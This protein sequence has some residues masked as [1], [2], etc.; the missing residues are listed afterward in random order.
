M[1]GMYVH[2]S[3]H[4]N[5][6][7]QPDI[8]VYIFRSEQFLKAMKFEFVW[9]DWDPNVTPDTYTLPKPEY[10]SEMLFC[11]AVS[12][13]TAVNS[14]ISTVCEWIWVKYNFVILSF[15]YLAKFK[16][17]INMHI[18]MTYYIL[19]HN[20]R[21]ICHFQLIMLGRHHAHYNHR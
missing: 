14:R 7:F 15:F 10:D 13:I 1:V 11:I 3:P 19:I 21:Q 20:S 2:H 18:Y 4:L 16:Q 5:I 6:S 9:C 12:L 8:S 17:L